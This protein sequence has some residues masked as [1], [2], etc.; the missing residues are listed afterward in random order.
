MI[1]NRVLVLILI[2]F[3]TSQCLISQKNSPEEYLK[4]YKEIAIQEMKTY[5][6]PASIT[7]AQG[8]LESSYGNSYLATEANNHFGIKCHKEWT[9]EHVSYDDDA[10][11]ECFRKYKNA[12]QSFEDH[13]LFLSTRPRYQSLFDLEIT[14]YKAWAFGLKKAGYATNPKY[15]EQL[16]DIIER[17]KLF[18]FDSNTDETVDSTVVATNKINDTAVQSIFNP[19]VN[20]YESGRAIYNYNGID[21]IIVKK[22]YDWENVSND[23]GL[24]VQSLRKYNE[25]GKNSTLKPGQILYLSPKKKKAPT[26]YHYVI[27]GETMYSISQRY[28]VKLKTLYHKNLMAEGTEPVLGQKIWLR[29]KKQ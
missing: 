16:I 18:Q 9:G 23:V 12:L 10:K 11:G 8:M 13:S 17:Y 7:L 1:F 21:Y 28:G 24:S 5:N 27:K 6:I 4:K 3:T 2:L 19:I 20:W 15:A 14:D 29:K 26:H 25:I 22:N